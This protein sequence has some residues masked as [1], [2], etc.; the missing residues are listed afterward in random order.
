M[1]QL[2]RASRRQTDDVAVRLE[3]RAGHPAFDTET[4]M[5]GHVA[6]LAMH[7]D[8]D[9]GANPVVHRRQFGATG[10]AGDMDE[11]LTIGDHPHAFFGQR[12]LDAAD[13]DFVAG[14]LLR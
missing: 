4:G 9:F 11:R 6:E 13:R 5:F 3:H 2:L 8:Q 10:M 14:N 7:R 1:A 12:I